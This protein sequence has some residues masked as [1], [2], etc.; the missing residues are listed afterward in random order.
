MGKGVFVGL[1]A[2]LILGVLQISLMGGAT[3]NLLAFLAILGAIIGAVAPKVKGFGLLPVGAGVGAA[4]YAAY[5]F[6]FNFELVPLLITG[7][8]V[9]LLIALIAKFVVPMLIK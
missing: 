9:G 5:A 2:G 7:L 3:W 1:V 8:V 4:V 6:M